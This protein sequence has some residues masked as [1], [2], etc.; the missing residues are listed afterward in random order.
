M[1]VGDEDALPPSPFIFQ[2]QEDQYMDWDATWD[3]TSPSAASPTIF[4][5]NAVSVAFVPVKFIHLVN[6]ATLDAFCLHFC[7]RVR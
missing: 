2:D 7:P 6:Q 4:E 3:P 5:R 1:W